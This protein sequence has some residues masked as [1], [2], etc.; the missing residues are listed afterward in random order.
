MDFPVGIQTFED[1]VKYKLFYVDKTE[2]VYQLGRTKGYY[3]LSRPRRF[4]KSLL[5]STLEAYFLGKKELFEGLKMAE[6]E[7]KW[8][9]YPV[10]HIDLNSEN[11]SNEDA[12][13]L[14]LEN[15][16]AKWEEEYGSRPSEKTVSLRFSG[17]I[18]R[19][20][21]KTGKPVVVLIDEYDKPLTA[22]IDNEELNEN[23][24][25]QLRAF[26][27]VLKSQDRYIRFAML[28]GVTKFSKVSV[29][30]DINQLQDISL[31]KQYQAICGITDEE[32]DTYCHESIEELA[33]ENNTDY[34]DMREQ[35]RKKYDGYHFYKNGIGI[36]NPFSLLMAF[37]RKELS[38]YW[39]ETATTEFL[40]RLIKTSH[41]P[42]EKLSGGILTAQQLNGKID[43]KTNPLPI[44]Y[45][46][47]YLTIT[48]FDN[49]TNRYVLGFPNEE[50]KVGFSEALVPAYIKTKNN[51]EFD[52][53]DFI[54]DLLDG[55]IEQF[56]KRLQTLFAN[57]DYEIMG[58]Q[59]RDFQNVMQVILMLLS[60]QVSVE[61]HTSDGRMDIEMETDDYVAI[62]ELKIDKSADEA[63][64]QI[65]EK[66]YAAPFAM[67]GK[68]I[69]K[70]GVNFSS[71]TRRI[72][73]Y[74]IESFFHQD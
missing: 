47:G 63:L 20:Y 64:K 67:S 44:M 30:S 1:I 33:K 35:L 23:F 3:F 29:F 13:Q 36:Y 60:T 21:E 17:I 65:E 22:T 2:Y 57:L 12:L 11:Y 45:Q 18:E 72:E 27:G 37:R 8:E 24:R 53:F 49:R 68:K 51:T 25:E 38:D 58:G 5:I 26:Y 40:V 34:A 28:T 7:Q 61:R 52:Y 70:V 41:L 62:F 66:N 9:S 55:D 48:G 46:A 32:L 14:V 74:K 71:K 56:M 16:L 4:G 15:Y 59:E 31:A 73:E 69:Y 39:F 10:F 19:A 54:N 43:F 42:I 50:V 6:L